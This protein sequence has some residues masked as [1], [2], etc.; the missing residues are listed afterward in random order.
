ML[1][2]ATH[3]ENVYINTF[4]ILPELRGRGYGRQMLTQIVR[5]LS[6]E[7]KPVLLEVEAENQNALSLYLSCGFEQIN[8]YRYWAVLL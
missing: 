4:S 7:G 3:E 1:R 8:A 2:V 6:G 5:L